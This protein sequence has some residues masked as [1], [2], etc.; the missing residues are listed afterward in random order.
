M[1]K[2]SLFF[3][4]I[5]ETLKF[6]LIFKKLTIRG[7]SPCQKT[8]QNPSTSCRS[9]YMSK[10]K[11]LPQDIIISWKT[12]NQRHP[13]VLMEPE[14]WQEGQEWDRGHL[15]KRLGEYRRSARPKASSTPNWWKIVTASRIHRALKMWWQGPNSSACSTPTRTISSKQAIRTGKSTTRAL[16]SEIT[17]NYVRMTALTS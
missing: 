8:E 9:R 5:P 16:A 15:F 10:K 2:R 1:P 11:K 7:H 14:E 17:T 6:R 3:H 13:W 12:E 4:R